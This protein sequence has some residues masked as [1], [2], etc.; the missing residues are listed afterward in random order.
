MAAGRKKPLQQYRGTLT[1]SEIAAG[2]NAASRNAMRLVEDAKLLIDAGRF[3]TACSLAILAIEERGKTSILRGLAIAPDSKALQEAWSDYRNHHSKN[4]MWIFIELVT[5]GARKLSE[6]SC[7]FEPNSEHPSLIDAIKQLGFYTDCYVKGRWSEPS[8]A[9]N[10]EFARMM[11][12][13]AELLCSERDV[14]PREVELW[15]EH[16]GPHHGTGRMTQGLLDFAQ[17]MEE[18]G[19]GK[20]SVDQMSTFVLGRS[21]A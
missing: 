3:P 11:T 12:H 19:L 6:F 4:A 15:I 21:D 5:K 7:I 14:T 1:A 13:T 16:V 17:A 20:L 8:D 10:E 18:E 2:M 9:I